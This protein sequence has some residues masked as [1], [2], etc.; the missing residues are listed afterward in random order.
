M[1]LT[2]KKF[3]GSGKLKFSASSEQHYFEQYTNDFTIRY[4]LGKMPLY[5]YRISGRGTLPNIF[6]PPTGFNNQI[7]Y[8]QIYNIFA[9]SI[10]ELP[11]KLKEGNFK[12]YVFK[13]YKYEKAVYN[14]QYLLDVASGVVDPNNYG[15]IDVTKEFCKLPD[16][17]DFCTAFY[18]VTAKATFTTDYARN[19]E[20][21]GTLKL[22]GKSKINNSSYFQYKVKRK[23][24]NR[25]NFNGSATTIGTNLLPTIT[26]QGT[27]SLKIKAKAKNQNNYL[28]FITFQAIANFE[29]INSNNYNYN[30]QENIFNPI[31]TNNVAISACGCPAN[32]NVI[33]FANNIF[34]SNSIFDKFLYRNNFASQEIIALYYDNKNK[35]YFNSIKYEGLGLI[36]NTKEL[37]NISTSLGCTDKVDFNQN[38]LW[39]FS[40]SITRKTF[41]NKKYNSLESKISL[42]LPYDLICTKIDAMEFYFRANLKEMV[43]Y[44][45]YKDKITNIEI[46]VFKDNIKLFS[47]GNWIS[48]PFFNIFIYSKPISINE[49]YYRQTVALPQTNIRNAI[50]GRQEIIQF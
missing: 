18:E 38:P 20:S 25:L 49:Q 50:S 15:F 23:I 7:V 47:S 24:K 21:N 2:N 9:R 46:S 6:K 34:K 44:N 41:Q 13:V 4:D 29:L 17:S 19:F 12:G 27:G 36:E 42:F 48:D 43:V 3:K 35:N 28:G 16:A 30:P 40:S 33:Y 32:T 26:Y 39:L 10:S 11:N 31:A 1:W 22:K 8:S 37:W 14:S 5:C 45:K